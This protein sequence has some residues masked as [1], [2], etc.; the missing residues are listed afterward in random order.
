MHAFSEQLSITISGHLKC[1]SLREF[2]GGLL[3]RIWH[4]HCCGSDLIPGLGIEIPHQTTAFYSQKKKI[5]K[6]IIQ[7]FTI[8]GSLVA[9]NIKHPALL[10]FGC[11]FTSWPRNLHILQVWPEKK[12]IFAMVLD[13]R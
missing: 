1:N 7:I 12:K 6:K 11:R 13:N 10:H 8:V 3:V 2:H 5:K 9:Q 4:S